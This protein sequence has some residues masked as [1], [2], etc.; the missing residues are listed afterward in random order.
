M[1]KALYYRKKKKYCAKANKSEQYL[2]NI[3][4]MIKVIC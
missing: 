2:I 3:V 4:V 1:S